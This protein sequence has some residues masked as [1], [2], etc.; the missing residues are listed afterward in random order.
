MASRNDGAWVE[1]SEADLLGTPD[2]IERVF[3]AEIPASRSALKNR[4]QVTF[5]RYGET[6]VEALVRRA[7]PAEDALDMPVESQHRPATPRKPRAAQF[8]EAS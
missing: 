8:Q 3:S 5:V 4:N 2:K 6:L 7:Q 1:Y